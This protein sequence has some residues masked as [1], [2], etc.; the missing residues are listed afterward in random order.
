MLCLMHLI[1]HVVHMYIIKKKKKK[2]K[3][4]KKIFQKKI[5][6]TRGKGPSVISI[7]FQK[8]LD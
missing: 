6:W 2:K 8:S 1:Y 4:K 3:L 7:H 5:F